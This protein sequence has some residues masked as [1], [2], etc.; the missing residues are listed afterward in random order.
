[1]YAGQRS[2]DHRRHICGDET[3]AKKGEIRF[4][5]IHKKLHEREKRRKLVVFFFFISFES[6]TPFLQIKIFKRDEPTVHCS[7]MLKGDAENS[8]G[9]DVTCYD[10]GT[11]AFNFI[12]TKKNI[13]WVKRAGR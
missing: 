1:M 8:Y 11:C 2:R 7:T 4:T 9:E 13:L 12:G 3:V 5:R 10:N 6:R